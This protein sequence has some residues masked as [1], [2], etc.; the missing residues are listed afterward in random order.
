MHFQVGAATLEIL[1]STRESRERDSN[2]LLLWLLMCPSKLQNDDNG[3]VMLLTQ[4]ACVTRLPTTPTQVC[5]RQLV[6]A[7]S[8][9]SE[10]YSHSRNIQ[11]LKHSFVVTLL[12]NWISAAHHAAAAAANDEWAGQEEVLQFYPQVLL[13]AFNYYRAGSERGG[14]GSAVSD[15]MASKVLG[16]L[17]LC[18][19]I[20]RSALY[21]PATTLRLWHYFLL[22]YN[23]CEQSKQHPNG[24]WHFYGCSP[25]PVPGPSTHIHREK[26][27]LLQT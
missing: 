9:S 8:S 11:T 4:H 25:A 20:T 18:S 15:K 12:A 21:G 10:Y 2:L 1:H 19:P 14:R 27:C 17:N 5:L 23:A 26:R 6:N 7:N 24:V 22:V 13:C 3:F 16:Q